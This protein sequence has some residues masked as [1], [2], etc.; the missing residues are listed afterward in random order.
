ME[1]ERIKDIA[2][3]LELGMRCF[4]HS[5]LKETKFIPDYDKY[6]HMDS[7]MFPAEEQEIES[8]PGG[9]IEI[10]GM[11]SHES[12][13]VMEDFIETVDNEGLTEKLIQALNGPKPFRNFKFIID[14]SGPYRDRWFKFK[15]KKLS[16]WVENQLDEK[17]L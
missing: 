9:Y 2:E 1:K 16:D 11:N 17:A 15:D 6:P 5:E 12:F 13:K 4:V 8:R 14:N 3:N 10:K 7:E